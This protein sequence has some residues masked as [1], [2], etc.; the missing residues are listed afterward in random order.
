MNEV[1][2]SVATRA[3][4]EPLSAFRLQGRSFWSRTAI[5]A[6]RKC[7][8]SQT[9]WGKRILEQTSF[10]FLS[11]LLINRSKRHSTSRQKL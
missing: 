4:T 7:H 2:L 3:G 8:S 6:N 9:L 1:S 10:G 5:E 11:G